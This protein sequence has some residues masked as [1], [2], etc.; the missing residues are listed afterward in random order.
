MLSLFRKKVKYVSIF[1][2][3]FDFT[4]YI[5]RWRNIWNKYVNNQ[6]ANVWL[7]CNWINARIKNITSINVSNRGLM[8][9]SSSVGFS[10]SKRKKLQFPTSSLISRMERRFAQFF[11]LFFWLDLRVTRN[12]GRWLR[13]PGPGR[14]Y[15][16]F[17]RVTSGFT[18][19]IKTLFT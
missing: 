18:A 10:I 14:V 7:R 1:S 19:P 11:Q 2:E 12:L 13:V 5:V 3:W 8:S 17:R 6:I 4:I 9:S 16:G 15:V